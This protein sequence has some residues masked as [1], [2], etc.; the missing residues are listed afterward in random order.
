MKKLIV[1]LL[2]SSMCGCAWVAWVGYEDPVTQPPPGSYE[3]VEG[4]CFR[5]G[6]QNLNIDQR[7]AIL[8]AAGKVCQ[9]FDS[10]DFQARV[11]GQ[12]WIA[13]CDGNDGSPKIITGE[14]VYLLLQ[15]EV[16]DFSV[17]PMWPWMA[18]AQAQKSE[19]DHVKNRIAIRPGRIDRWYSAEVEDRGALINTVA[20]EITHLISYN[21]R[22]RGHGSKA[23]PDDKLVSYG[24]GNLVEELGM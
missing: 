7:R 19:N 14:E 5:V 11:E 3:L 22:D 12:E 16:P 20:H 17:N 10:K 15:E 9:V 2:C 24:I 4:G 13:S 23:C 8:G 21:F 1:L 18:I 6:T